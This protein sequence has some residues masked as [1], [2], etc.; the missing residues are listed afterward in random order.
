MAKLRTRNHKV[1]LARSAGG[2]A[3]ITV[4]LV[5]LG[6]FMFLP[7]LYVI[8]QSLKPLDELWMYPPRF[9]VTSPTLKNFRDLF[10]LMNISWVPFSRYI[11]NT[12]LVS[13]AGTFG[14]LLLASMAAY[15]LAKI[16]FPGKN[17]MF[18][19]VQLSLMFNAT[20]TTITS[21]ILM[22][23]LHWLDTYW[24][25]I[26]P[27]WGSTLG[28]YLMKQ[29]ME[30][31]REDLALRQKVEQ[32]LAR[33]YGSFTV[34]SALMSPEMLEQALLC[35]KQSVSLETSTENVMSVEVPRYE[36]K[37]ASEDGG[38]IYPY[39]FAQTSG[40]LDDAVREL[41]DILPDLLRLAEIEKATQ[42][43]AAEIERTRRRVNALEYVK[44]PQMQQS[45]KYIT[46]KLDENERANTIRLM[47]VKDMILQEA[48]E[49][50]RQ[51][52]AAEGAG[53]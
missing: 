23:E 21:F 33:A 44:I 29:F 38:N 50:R 15:A 42:L 11:F 24:A 9:I 34:A 13:V 47:K 32:S 52:D 37:L 53:V 48:I 26:V 19:L 35:P 45:I 40:E 1:V 4:L 39:G 14:H 5:I 7:M 17:G 8:M 22:S 41:G 6:V 12:V 30:V 2:D 10:T 31:V 28:L 27:A 18:Q 36:F 43:L 3:G 20:V 25:L 16:K 51:T 49:E 46:M